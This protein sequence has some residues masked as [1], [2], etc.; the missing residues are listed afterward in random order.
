MYS[1]ISRKNQ[2]SPVGERLA[3]DQKDVVVNGGIGAC[4][5]R[6]TRYKI[7]EKKGEEKRKFLS[8]QKKTG[9]LQG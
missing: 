2:S 8:D 4:K 5:V 9:P 7:P 3:H 6:N 1:L